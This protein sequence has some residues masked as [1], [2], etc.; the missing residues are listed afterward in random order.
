MSLT[1][2]PLVQRQ[3]EHRATQ[4]L[5][6]P[7]A[8]MLLGM[9]AHDAG[10]PGRINTVTHELEGASFELVTPLL[11]KHGVNAKD[12][13]AVKDIVLSTD[14]RVGAQHYQTAHKTTCSTQRL[15]WQRLFVQEADVLAS[16]L[17]QLQ[18][19]L[20]RQL[21]KEWAKFNKK[22]AAS[23]LKS[24]GRLGFLEGCTRFSTPAARSIGID[25]LVAK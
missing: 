18:A 11:K 9:E 3:V 7:E 24:S 1:A 23:L 19:E 22:A 4:G 13:R 2:L 5:N 16:A 8:R 6:P 25:K 12:T 15:A 10:H 17:P 20:T 21:A 14:Q